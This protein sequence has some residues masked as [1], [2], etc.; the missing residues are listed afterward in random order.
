MHQPGASCLP[1][2]LGRSRRA[3]RGGGVRLAPTVDSAR[4]AGPR[5]AAW[6]HRRPRPAWLACVTAQRH[7][8][9]TPQ[10]G[11]RPTSQK[12]WG[13]RRRR[14]K[15]PCVSRTWARTSSLAPP[16]LKNFA[17]GPAGCPAGWP[18]LVTGRTRERCSGGD[19][20]RRLGR[21]RTAF[22]IAGTAS[23]ALANRC[24]HR[25]RVVNMRSPPRRLLAADANA[26]QCRTRHPFQFPLR[27][28]HGTPVLPPDDATGF[29]ALTRTG[30]PGRTGRVP[31]SPPRAPLPPPRGG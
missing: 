30:T 27:R 26:R 25:Q 31:R 18:R 4:A 6:T 10:V 8:D 7:P 2:A 20:D 3:C 9:W 14:G 5:S 11:P 16:L 13:Q 12:K 21:P 22:E 23:A 17:A 19:P 1:G 28:P 15:A 29:T 24:H